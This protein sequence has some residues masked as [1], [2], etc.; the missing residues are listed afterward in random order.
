VRQKEEGA[1]SQEEDELDPIEED[2][3]LL[4]EMDEL[5]PRREKAAKGWF[6]GGS[7]LARM[8]SGRL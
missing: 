1:D 4:R 7:K 2:E 5:G 3:E 8:K 6:T